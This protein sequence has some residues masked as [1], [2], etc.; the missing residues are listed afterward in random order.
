[1]FIRGR[2]RFRM[3][4]VATAVALVV[5]GVVPSYADHQAGWPGNPNPNNNMTHWAP[6]PGTVTGEYTPWVSAPTDAF[7]SNPAAGKWP[8]TSAA[9]WRWINAGGYTQ[10]FVVGAA[11]PNVACPP[12]DPN[13]PAPYNYPPD[14]TKHTHGS[15]NIWWAGGIVVCFSDWIDP[16]F[17]RHAADPDPD[18]LGHA[19]LQ[20]L[21]TAP[22][23]TAGALVKVCFNCMNW[24]SQLQHIVFT[25]EY[26][27]A[28]G[29]GHIANS[30]YQ[31]CVMWPGAA[32][33]TPCSHDKW[34]LADTYQHWG[35]F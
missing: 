1:M 31:N 29:L 18:A 8:L 22:T 14:L 16:D 30:A 17:N 28:I 2:R 3:P 20:P 19:R 4:V 32:T 5:M 25:H 27:H 26:G 12:P 23:H 35:G 24:G 7:T 13:P 15:H 6:Q 21:G 33:E 10:G 9:E 34:A 11:A